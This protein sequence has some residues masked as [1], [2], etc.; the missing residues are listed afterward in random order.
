MSTGSAQLF[1]R[2]YTDGCTVCFA[3]L[4]DGGRYLSTAL[5][6][7]CMV[8]MELLVNGLEDS[9]PRLVGKRNRGSRRLAAGHPVTVETHR[10][11][12]D[13]LDAQQ[14]ATTRWRKIGE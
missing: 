13:G 14:D 5:C 9:L 3:N 10:R 6:V 1:Q 7:D 8:D 4:R 12:A 2:I 11:E